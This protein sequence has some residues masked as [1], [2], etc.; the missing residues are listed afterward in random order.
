MCRVT[1]TEREAMEDIGVMTGKLDPGNIQTGRVT[2]VDNKTQCSGQK[3]ETGSA[4]HS[5]T[6]TQ[7]MTRVSGSGRCELEETRQETKIL[8]STV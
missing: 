5:M 2:A 4:T 6:S 3:K 1:K 8:D 7:S